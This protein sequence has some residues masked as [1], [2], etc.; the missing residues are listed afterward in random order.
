MMMMTRIKIIDDGYDDD[1][2]DVDD[3]ADDDDDD[4]AP[5]P[6]KWFCSLVSFTCHQTLTSS[7]GFPVNCCQNL[8]NF[9]IVLLILST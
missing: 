2:Y 9:S 6:C 1:D 7:L 4:H 5:S 3:G 8:C